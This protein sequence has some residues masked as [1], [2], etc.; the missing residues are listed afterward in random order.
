MDVLHD[1]NSIEV[2]YLSEEKV[3]AL[4]FK[5]HSKSEEFRGAWNKALE[6]AIEHKATRWLM[7]Q[8]N[9]S[10]FPEDQ[11]WVETDWFPRSMEAIPLRVETPRYV[12]IVPSKNFFVEFSAKKF[13]KEN[14]MPGFLIKPHQDVESAKEWLKNPELDEELAS[15]AS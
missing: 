9:Q 7:D 3:I 10:I 12:A 1:F 11:K 13:M 2:R 6:L 4:E 14:S 8:R 5:K 15:L